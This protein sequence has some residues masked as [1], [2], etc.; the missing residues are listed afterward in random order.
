[1]KILHVISTL[2]YGGAE[3]LLS[4]L[5]IRQKASGLDVAVHVL[6]K[7]DTY[8]E[9]KVEKSGVS[10]T[11]GKG[12]WYNVKQFNI[13][14]KQINLF[15]PDLIHTHLTPSQLWVAFTSHPCRITTE[16]STLNRRRTPYLKWFDTFLYSKFKKI[17]CISQATADA[18]SEWLPGTQKKLSVIPN[19]IDLERFSASVS[20]G[21][22]QISTDKKVIIVV[23]R[24][25][26]VKDHSTLIR[27]LVGVKDA[28]L[29]LVGDGN[30]RS[31]LEELVA[32]LG[33]THRVH[34]LGQ[35]TDV[36]QLLKRAYIYV[37]CSKWEGFGIATLEAMA[38]GLPV[39][40]SDV[41]GLR[42]VVGKAGL[43]FAPGDHESLAKHISTLLTD[44]ALVSKYGALAQARARD[45]SLE[46][47]VKAY[48][49]LYEDVTSCLN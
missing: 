38:A 13:L 17:V 21:L 4:E 33:L 31:D 7:S 34:F 32:S 2:G 29:L 26:V 44:D 20:A 14:K 37:Q 46:A 27:A 45:F 11:Y 42:D 30:L 47:T 19:G 8:L 1:M 24:L 9:Q 25:E 6:C 15:K 23:G 28:Q 5:L 39:I 3:M 49:V 36:P 35:R 16:H 41:P 48:A 43:V 10:I 40:V 18:L 12:G 22:Q